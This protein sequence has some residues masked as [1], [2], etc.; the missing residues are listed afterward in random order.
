MNRLYPLF[1]ALFMS[2]PSQAEPTEYAC[3][4]V[5]FQ[6]HD[7][8]GWSVLT[9]S[10]FSEPAPTILEGA[11][12]LQRIEGRP[13][14][15]IENDPT[16]AVAEWDLDGTMQHFVGCKYSGLAAL[17]VINIS[18]HSRCISKSLGHFTCT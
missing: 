10:T 1:L 8:R 2:A 12:I 3:P 13:N 7:H 16:A 9:V 15:I 18:I 4:P 11:W 17:L 5:G 6:A 14:L